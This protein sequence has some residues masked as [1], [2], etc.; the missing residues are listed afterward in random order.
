MTLQASGAISFSE[1]RDEY[2]DSGS[3]SMSEFYRNGSLVPDT[4]VEVGSTVGPRGYFFGVGTNVD[5]TNYYW[6]ISSTAVWNNSTVSSNTGGATSFI[7]G[8]F[9]YFRGAFFYNDGAENY[10][11][12]SRRSY[13]NTPANQDVPES[14]TVT[15]SD[16]YGGRAS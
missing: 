8:G 5:G 7:A 4:V 9:Q 15:L 13:S 10:Y 3:V 14:G 2:G 12:I 16:F 11:Q 1:I 6:V